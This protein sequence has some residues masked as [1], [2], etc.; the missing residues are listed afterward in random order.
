MIPPSAR[1]FAAA[2]RICRRH[3]RTF[4]FSSFFL[5]R[6]KRLD[7]YAVYAFCRLIDDA[8][9]V[10]EGMPPQAVAGRLSAFEAALAEIYLGREVDLAFAEGAE[11][12][13]ALHA[14]A[15][16]VNRLG[17]PREHFVDLA[18][19]CAQDLT[20]SRYANFAE[21][22]RYC[23]LVAGVVGLVMCRVFGMA[24][25]AALGRAV[26]MG[27]AMQ[28]TNI[29][30]DVKEDYARGRV[31]LPHDE[32]DRFGYGESDL[33]AGLVDERFRNLMQ[34][35]IARTRALYAEAERGLCRLPAD[36]SRQTACVMARVYAGILDAIERQD[37]DVFHRRASLSFTQKLLR[38]PSS[39][40]LALC[41]R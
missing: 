19:G 41:G 23:Y 7:A 5:P 10:A 30:R 31:Y 3:A 6:R 28:L 9:D 34:F 37:Y 40:R 13:L 21:L 16:T 22:E 25:P 35:Q 32:M 27:N 26:Q 17:I 20:V 29:L 14:F 4:H 24:D 38:V 11:A 36:G 8:V 15:D 12:R 33:A 18:H 1:A 2:E 39:M